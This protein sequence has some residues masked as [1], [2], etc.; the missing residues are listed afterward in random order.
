MGILFLRDGPHQQP[1]QF[2]CLAA[3]SGSSCVVKQLI[4]VSYFPHFSNA[5]WIHHNTLQCFRCNDDV[6][7][8]L[9]ERGIGRTVGSDRANFYRPDHHHGITHSRALG[10]PKA[11]SL[12]SS[13]QCKPTK[14]EYDTHNPRSRP[15]THLSTPPSYQM[16][17]FGVLHRARI[18]LKAQ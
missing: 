13:G 14:V 17:S 4:S 2:C 3:F 6:D 15:T 18:K 10:V 9:H 11:R 16:T 12:S 8:Q 5:L 7:L 1:L